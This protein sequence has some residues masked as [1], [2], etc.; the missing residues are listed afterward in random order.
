MVTRRDAGPTPGM[1]SFFLSLGK[2]YNF[3]FFFNI[4]IYI[5]IYIY[6]H[7]VTQK[8]KKNRIRNNNNKKKY[9]GLKTI[10]SYHARRAIDCTRPTSGWPSRDGDGARGQSSPARCVLAP[11][12]PGRGQGEA[13][14]LLACLPQ[15]SAERLAAA[16][17]SGAGEEVRGDRLC[18]S[19]RDLVGGPPHAGDLLDSATGGAAEGHLPRA[20]GGRAQALG[21]PVGLAVGCSHLHL[22]PGEG[23]KDGQ[24]V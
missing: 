11:H 15:E 20:R 22:V 17:P 6:T 4:Y 14:G 18:P 12:V 23:R 2:I 21:L 9:S 19:Y 5:D 24:G 7:L 1:G 3:C 8:E 10:H 13:G 16:R